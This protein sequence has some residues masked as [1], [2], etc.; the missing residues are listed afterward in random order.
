MRS[1]SSANEVIPGS[2]TDSASGGGS[3]PIT[4]RSRAARTALW[5]VL[6]VGIGLVGCGRRDVLT[7]K[8]GY[9]APPGSL[10]ALSADEFARVANERLAG[11]ARVV[12]YGSS[13]LGNDRTLM[14]KLKLGTV[15]LAVPATVMSSE[16]PAFALFEMPYLVRDRAH[17]R[18]L[19]DSL[20]WTELVPRAEARGYHILAIW[21]NG[22]RHVTN[23]VR[24]IYEPKDLHGIKIRTP[25]SPW[26]VAVFRALGANPS[27]M[28]F[29]ELFMAL[30]T[31]VMDGQENPLS[32]IVNASLNE[33][34]KYLSLTGHVYSPAYLTAGAE[35]WSRLPSDVR[36][37]LEEVARSTRT[38]VFATA[39]EI[40]RNALAAL[41]AR[42]MKVNEVD[43]ER[44]IRASVPVYREFGER[45]PGGSEWIRRALELGN[46]PLDG[47]E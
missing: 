33:V 22:F 46:A 27:P 9:A 17:A 5:G 34:Q 43:R 29:S 19:E 6:A 23:N 37:I 45:V 8:L 18:L 32:N 31:G 10:I 4:S 1:T 20:V 47:R 42:S 44:F 7:L 35:R 14:D 11:R 39:A 13:Q 30:R 28:P 40:D 16:V 41:R 3:T 26:R 15:E 12:V 2:R 21:E 24:P 36:E 38:F 25:N